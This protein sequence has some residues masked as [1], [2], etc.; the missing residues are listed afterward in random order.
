MNVVKLIARASTDFFSVRCASIFSAEAK[1]ERALAV[2]SRFA[3]GNVNLQM[4]RVL[5]ER[6]LTK[7]MDKYLKNVKEGKFFFNP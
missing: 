6:D 3:R 1:E 5:T 7:Q 4:G 2:V